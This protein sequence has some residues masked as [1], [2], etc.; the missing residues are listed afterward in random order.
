MISIR[1]IITI[2]GKLTKSD[3]YFTLKLT[4]ICL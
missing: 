3:R 4:A 2:A 1:V